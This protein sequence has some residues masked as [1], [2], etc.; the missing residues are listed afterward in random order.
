MGVSKVGLGFMPPQPVRI[1]GRWK[2]KQL[3]I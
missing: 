1:S 2:H 3:V